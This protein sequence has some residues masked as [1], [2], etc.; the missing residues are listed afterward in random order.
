METRQYGCKGCSKSCSI[1][2]ELEQ[3]RVSRIVGNGCQKG[4]DMVLNFILMD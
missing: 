2:V 4:K 3:G 1:R